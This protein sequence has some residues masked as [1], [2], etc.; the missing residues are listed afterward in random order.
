MEVSVSRS[1][2][3]TDVKSFLFWPALK[4]L[5]ESRTSTK[6]RTFFFWSAM[7]FS[8]ENRATIRHAEKFLS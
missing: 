7:I 5:E 1:K 3:S 6:V 4:F 8:E 2:T